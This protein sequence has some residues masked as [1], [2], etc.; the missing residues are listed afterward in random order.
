M[1]AKGMGITTKESKALKE[2]TKAL[3]E[4]NGKLEEKFKI[5]NEAR[6]KVNATLKQQRDS[7]I[8]NK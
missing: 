5:Q 8:C 6:Q 7:Y 2:A 1:I 4:E 3:A